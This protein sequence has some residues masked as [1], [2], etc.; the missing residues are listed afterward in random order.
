MKDNQKYFCIERHF[1]Q[2]LSGKR[3]ENFN[4]AKVMKVSSW[5]LWV[6]WIIKE[7]DLSSK[8]WL[9]PYLPIN[10]E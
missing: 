3:I 4:K 6:W 9:G 7:D 1:S 2:F 5:N 10:L 8:I